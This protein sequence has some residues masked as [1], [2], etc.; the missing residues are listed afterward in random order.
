V[1]DKLTPH[2]EVPE[3]DLLERAIGML[4]GKLG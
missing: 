3:G 2:V 1:V 4:K